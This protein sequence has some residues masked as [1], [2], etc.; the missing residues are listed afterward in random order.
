VLLN[1]DADNVGARLRGARDELLRP[2]S[3]HRTTAM[4][5]RRFRGTYGL[6]PRA[7]CATPPRT[8]LWP[9]F[10][11]GPL[12]VALADRLWPDSTSGR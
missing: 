7:N 6:T 3:H 1:Y 4:V 12:T 11:I 9:G 8:S 2:D 10:G 5:A